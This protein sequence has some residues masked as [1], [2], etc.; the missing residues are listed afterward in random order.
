[1]NVPAGGRRY[2]RALSVVSSICVAALVVTGVSAS[3]VFAEDPPVDPPA[4]EV[5]AP[6]APESVDFPSAVVQA[7]ATGERV[8]VTAERSESSTTWVNPEGTVTVTQYAAPVRFRDEDGQWREFDTTLVEGEDGSIAPAAVPGGVELAGEVEG[9]AGDPAA[10][11]SID[12]EGGDSVAI[13]WPGSLGE[14]ELEGNAAVYAGAWP[15]IDLVVHATRDGFEQS[16]V[17][18]DREALLE[19]TGPGAPGASDGGGDGPAASDGGGEPA[20]PVDGA[21]TWDVPLQVDEGL[22]VREVKGERVEFVDGDGQVVSRF[23]APLAWDAEVD[24]ASREHLNR[25]P[26]TVE[27]LAEDAGVVTLRL[28]VEAA[29]LLDEGRVFPVTV[30]PVYA[31]ATA[32]PTFDAYVQTNYSSDRSSEQELKVGTYDGSNKARSYLT[33]SNS[34]FKGVTVQSATLNLYETWSY[35][36]TASAVEVWSVSSVVSSSVRWSN[37]PALGA[38]QGSVTA[39]KG[40]SSSCKAGWVNIPITNL[41]KSWSTSSAS[42]V[43]LAVKAASETNV[44]G[45]KRFGSLES[46]TPP[47]ISFTFDRAPNVATMPTVSGAATSGS[48]TFVPAKRPTLGTTATDPDGNTV[49]AEIQVHSSSAGNADSLLGR[50]TTS[51]AASGATISCAPGF[52]L[53][54]NTTLYLRAKATDELGVPG[55]WSAWK[56]IKTAQKTPSKPTISCGSTY[57]NGGWVEQAPTADVSCT[58]TAPATTGNNQA[59]QLDYRVDGNTTA[60]SVAM[61]AGTSVTVKIPKATGGHQ[62]RARVITASRLTSDAAV[63]TTGWGGPSLLS[64]A[65]LSASNGTFRVSATAPGRTASEMTV[66]AQMQWRLAGTEDAWTNAGQ[67]RDVTGD[68]NSPVTLEDTFDAAAALAASGDISRAPVRME[69]QVCFTYSGVTAPSCTGQTQESVLVRVPH[70]FGGGYPT[71]DV[72][73]GQVALY[74]GEFQHTATDVSVPG[75]GSDITIDRTHLSSTGPGAVAAW[76]SDPVTGVFG[77]GF[78]ANLEGDDVSGMAGMDVVDQRMNDGTI[79]LID[80]DGEPLVF[81]NPSGKTGTVTGTLVS[82]TEDT[83]LSGVTA[84]ITGSAAAPTLKV[85]EPEG[86]VTTFAPVAGGASKNLQWRPVSITEPGQVGATTFGHDPATGVVSRIVAPVPDG[87]DPATCPTSGTLGAG[88]RAI[89]LTYTT[90]TDPT[91]K[92]AQRLTQVSAVMLDPAT[93]QVASRPVATYAYDS[94]TRLTKVTD[95]RSNLSTSYTWDGSTTRIKTITPSGLAGYTVNYAA[96]PDTSIPTQV[97]KNVQRG[98][99]TSGG[100]AV[101]IA[102]IAYGVPVSGSGRPDLSDAGIAAWVK[103]APGTPEHAAQKP[104]LGYAVFDADHPVST[105]KGADIP[106]TDLQYATVQY[107]NADAY[108]VNAATYGAGAWQITAARYD[109]QGN[110][111]REL[112]ASAIRTA[113]ADPSLDEAQINDLSTQTFYNAEQKNTDGDVVLPAGSVVTQTLGPARHVLRADGVTYDRLRPHT[114]TTYD[115]GAPHDGVNPATGQA[116]ALP[117]QVVV[118]A[119]ATDSSSG[120]ITVVEEIS[121]TTTGYA[122]IDG[123]SVDDASSGWVL[124]VATTATDAAG[125]TTKMRLDSRGKVVE[126]RQPSSNGTDAGTTKTIYYTAASN[127]ADASCGASVQAKA[128]AGQVCRIYPAA[129]PSAG[130]ALPS[131]KVTGYDYWLAPTTTVETSGSATRTSEVKY[132]AAGRHIWTKTTTNGVSGSVAIDPIFIQYNQTTGLVDA[133]GVSNAMGTGIS[134]AKDSYTYDLWGKETSYTNQ[135]GEKTTTGYDAAARVTTITDPKGTVTF[136]YDGNDATGN[137]ERRGLVTRQTVT[138]AGGDLLVYGAAYDADGAMTTETMPGAITTRHQLD[139]AGLQVGLSYSGQL[140]DPDTG[141]VSTGEWIAWSQTND[142]AGRVRTDATTFA[143]SIAT[144]AGI[145]PDG[146][147]TDPITGTEIAFDHRYTYSPAG[148]LTKVEDLTGAPVGETTVSPYTVRDYTFTPNGARKTLKETIRADGTPTGT[149]TT[150]INQTLSYDTADRLTG[151]YVYDP[152]GRQTTLPA[153]HAP[154]PEAGDVQLGYFD[155]D[156]PQKV[157]QDDTAT[158]FT[159]DVAARRLVQTS[160]TGNEVTTTTRHYADSSDNPS[161]IDTKRPDG[162]VETVRYTSSVSGNLGASIA[163]NGATSLMLSNMYGD[164][165]TSIPIPETAASADPATSIAGWSSYTEYGTPIDPTHTATVATSAGYGWLG[166]KERST[167]AGTAGLT[168]MGV[169]YYNPITASF[170]G[171]DP[172]VGGNA[173]AF[174]YPTDPINNCDPTGLA[175]C[176]RKKEGGKSKFVRERKQ[177]TASYYDQSRRKTVGNMAHWAMRLAIG[178]FFPSTALIPFGTGIH[179]VQRSTWWMWKEWRYCTT[180]NQW[181]YWYQGWGWQQQRTQYSITAAW[182]KQ[183]VSSWQYGRA[184]FTGKTGKVYGRL[185]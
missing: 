179:R 129:A 141:E 94:S 34:A 145:T 161:W 178:R 119:A 99:Q 72:E 162:S 32:K 180:G 44:Q 74:T 139:E 81:V 35:S 173:T 182:G 114:V 69:F 128:W 61:S 168:L 47:S 6:V 49:S 122:P 14:P 104:V 45:W 137:P 22:Q 90:V 97:V 138:R 29:W 113:I 20:S 4:P 70:A 158:T 38:K 66:S 12:T 111:T 1:M 131:Q 15:G 149:P 18:S 150:G 177:V 24:E 108:T 26:V 88:C 175:K 56:V 124:G 169:R 65:A 31:S 154:D 147:V 48:D 87:M 121:K 130:P 112:D 167:T 183:W 92:Q 110:I 36:C 107:V 63:F 51:K 39:A 176:S 174:S 80:E 40:F 54:D 157:T 109:E 106:G 73:M 146:E 75:Y 93:G 96:N 11:A 133:V 156:L 30:D 152:M 105:V 126:T 166:A 50:C 172:V 140:T 52:D 127:S 132:D 7:R 153:A 82:G 171:L 79:S 42:S 27:V 33:F 102:S 184:S 148:H 59:V 25:A 77:P 68:L 142:V 9:S 95:V 71:T 19:Y 2:R 41:A 135:L 60:T 5:S 13:A 159:L 170:T 53:P 165:V 64:P 181:Q 185:P 17:I 37:Q 3:P 100:Q 134:G 43:S 101:Q 83:D 117:T 123:K 89:D 21:V 125:N 155:N 78:T 62:I 103:D 118:S 28:G 58:V 163:S 84:S 164:V 115:Q 144:S 91:G 76:P 116:Y 85:T 16:F 98:A 67:A 143:S 10:V 8:E 151:G 86:T 23:E 160:T 120:E 55:G 136:A 57:T 46:T